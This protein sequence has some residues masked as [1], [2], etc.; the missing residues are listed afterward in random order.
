MNNAHVFALQGNLQ[1][2]DATIL[3]SLAGID[4]GVATTTLQLM[5]QSELT[6][7]D[8]AGLCEFVAKMVEISGISNLPPELRAGLRSII[9][10]GL[11]VASKARQTVLHCGLVLLSR[12]NPNWTIESSSTKSDPQRADSLGVGAF[13]ALYCSIVAT[14]LRVLMEEML[15][16]Y[17]SAEKSLGIVSLNYEINIFG[18]CC[19]ILDLILKFLIGNSSEESDPVWSLISPRA[20]LHI[21]KV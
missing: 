3:F 6:L 9:V 19:D 21:Q 1:F 7:S 5:L 4:H 18:E 12:L 13:A 17:M 2:S 14:E 8:I 16:K 10:Q 15:E 20:I 11:H